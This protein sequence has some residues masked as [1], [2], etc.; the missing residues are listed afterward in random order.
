MARMIDQKTSIEHSTLKTKTEKIVSVASLV[1]LLV[2]LV[3]FMQ[4]QLYIKYKKVSSQS[5]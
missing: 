2:W 4:Y 5:F 3:G 1:D